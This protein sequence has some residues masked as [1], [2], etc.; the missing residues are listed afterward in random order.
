MLLAE[1][2]LEI[3]RISLFGSCNSCSMKVEGRNVHLIH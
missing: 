2:D 1:F 3:S